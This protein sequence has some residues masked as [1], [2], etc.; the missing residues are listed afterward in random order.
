MYKKKRVPSFFAL[1]LLTLVVVSVI[2]LYSILQ[3]QFYS[4]STGET[5]QISLSPLS[6]PLE[7]DKCLEISLP[8][9]EFYLSSNLEADGSCMV[10]TADNVILNGN[11]H[12]LKGSGS[13][14]GIIV[15]PG[16]K[17]VTITN[18]VIS[19][20]N[21]GIE[22]SNSR[23]NLVTSSVVFDNSKYG[24]SI[25][26]GD[27][28][29]PGD[30]NRIEGNQIYGNGIYGIWVGRG[31]IGTVVENNKIV[32]SEGEAGLMLEGSFDTSVKGNFFGNSLDENKG[33]AIIGYSDTT[34]F[35][36]NTFT[37]F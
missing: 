4:S 26:G 7:V 22:I 10:V 32:N 3:N 21:T 27:Y 33:Q 17:N 30:E 19:Q 6:Y 13:G 12:S 1:A 15:A 11:G 36:S 25:N 16:I 37:G 34:L 28:R 23:Y 8:G 14:S 29:N 35:E 9:Q 20:F 31:V 2:A 18:F 5:E 24:I